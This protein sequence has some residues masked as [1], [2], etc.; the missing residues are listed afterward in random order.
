MSKITSSKPLVSVI[1]PCYNREKYVSEAIESVLAQSYPIIEIIVVDDGSTDKSVEIIK[2]SYKDS[3]VIFEQKNQGSSAARNTGIKNS[4]GEFLIFL[5]SDDYLS[6]DVIS[7]HIQAFHRWPEAGVFCS[8]WAFF[9]NGSL[10]EVIACDW[11]DKPEIPLEKIVTEHLPFPACLMYK[12]KYID[13]TGGFDEKMTNNT[14]CDLLIRTVLKG[15]KMVRSGEKSYAVYRTAPNS[16]TKT[17]G[18]IRFYKNQICLVNKLLAMNQ[19]SD[20]YFH[21]LIMK[22]LIKNRRKYWQVSLNWHLSLWPN[23]VAKFLYYLIRILIIDYGYLGYLI[24]Y[25]PWSNSY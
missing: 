16:I 15:A 20:P 14:D 12:R 5:D 8:N 9:R 4:H 6:N 1:I 24:K 19:C 25:K 10:S 11:P 3:V 7:D 21:S 17:H 18:A 23:D 2:R 22:R 13:L